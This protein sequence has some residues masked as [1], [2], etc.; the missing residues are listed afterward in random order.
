MLRR[1]DAFSA[2]GSAPSPRCDPAGIHR[3]IAPCHSTA[4][5]TTDTVLTWHSTA[6]PP[7]RDVRT[8]ATG[9]RHSVGTP[10]RHSSSASMGGYHSWVCSPARAFIDSS[11]AASIMRQL[12]A[13]S[14]VKNLTH[15]SGF[16]YTGDCAPFVPL[17]LSASVACA[18]IG[19][20][21]LSSCGRESTAAFPMRPCIAFP[22]QSAGCLASLFRCGVLLA[23]MRD[24]SP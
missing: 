23:W 2:F 19:R 8:T 15:G 18:G 16:P 17:A 21:S 5:R 11:H 10:L 14:G 24:Y 3:S 12:R 20:R 7:Q 9:D 13:F 22:M 6:P 4:R 1:I